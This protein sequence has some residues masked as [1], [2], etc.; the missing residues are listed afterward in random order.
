MRALSIRFDISPTEIQKHIEGIREW[1]INISYL[2][3]KGYQLPETIDFL[4]ARLIR[5]KIG[6]SLKLIPIIDSTNQY[7]LDS[8]S[9]KSGT[10]CISEH[11]TK[12]RGRRG[13]KWVSPF[14]KNLY[15]SMYW[16]LNSGIDSAVGLSI[17]IAVIIVEVLSTFGIKGVK[18]K[19]PND[20]C[21]KDRKLAGIL[22]ESVNK[23]SL[24]IGIGLNLLMKSTKEGISS[25]WT[26]LIEVADRSSLDR[27]E[28][29]IALI[30]ALYSELKYY[31][32]HG[33]R[34][35]IKR[36]NQLDNY[37]G[38]KVILLIGENKIEGIEHGINEKGALLIKTSK[39]LENYISGE[40]SLR[41][42]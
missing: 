36:W 32:L 8:S 3:E 17:V 7:L 22:I 21:Y 13:R 14:G 15:F 23:E 37:F 30:N 2:K 28:L 5:S 11:Q 12:G 18:L 10:V 34:K 39:G 40:I 9:I 4:N 16:K 6:N 35:F 27:N 19:W 24:V 31:E 26:S 42:Y 38:K 33:V 1:G 20:L 29:A 25:P 41:G